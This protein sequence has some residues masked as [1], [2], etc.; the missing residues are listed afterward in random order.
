MEINIGWFLVAFIV[1]FGVFDHAGGA[2][3][4]KALL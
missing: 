2:K 3:R 1:L 4:H